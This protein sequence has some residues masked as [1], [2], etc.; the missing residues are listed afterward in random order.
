MDVVFLDLR[1]VLRGMWKG[2]SV[3]CGRL[4]DGVFGDGRM[5]GRLLDFEGDAVGIIAINSSLEV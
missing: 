2:A 5:C 1:N 4:L 3:R